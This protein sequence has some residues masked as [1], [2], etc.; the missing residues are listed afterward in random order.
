MSYKIFDL[1]K[2]F[3][4]YKIVKNTIKTAIL[5]TIL[6]LYLYTNYHSLA[7]I[8]FKNIFDGLSVGVLL[9]RLFVV[10]GTSLWF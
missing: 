7:G 4:K 1:L 3:F 2:I 10:Y 5:E 9:L 8:F 6:L